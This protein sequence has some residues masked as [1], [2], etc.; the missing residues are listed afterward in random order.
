[1][2]E[3]ILSH[4]RTWLATVRG[5][6]LCSRALAAAPNLAHG[7]GQEAKEHN[8]EAELGWPTG[9]VVAGT[10]V[11]RAARR[12]CSNPTTATKGARPKSS[13]YITL[14]PP[15]SQSATSCVAGATCWRSSSVLLTTETCA[16]SRCRWAVFSLSTFAASGQSSILCS[17]ARRRKKS[18]PPG[19]PSLGICARLPKFHMVRSSHIILQRSKTIE[20]SS[21]K[22]PESSATRHTFSASLTHG[23]L[24]HRTQPLPANNKQRTIAMDQ[25][26]VPRVLK[27]VVFMLSA[28]SRAI[29][30]PT[31]R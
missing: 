6:P 25:G 19:P 17:P 4:S 27:S 18:P 11:R 9:F 21:V 16:S 5:D 30:S 14:P 3:L 8:R 1:M 7:E 2:I 12:R 23:R 28:D 31:T 24:C 22:H 13:R 15:A 20:P 10:K 26:R 29:L